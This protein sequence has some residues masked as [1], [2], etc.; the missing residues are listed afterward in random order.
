M[1]FN[2]FWWVYFITYPQNL[3]TSQSCCFYSFFHSWGHNIFSILLVLFISGNLH[4]LRNYT[5]FF[6]G[7]ALKHAWWALWLQL[8]INTWSTRLDSLVDDVVIWDPVVPEIL[9]QSLVH[10]RHAFQHLE[11]CSHPLQ[12]TYKLQLSVWNLFSICFK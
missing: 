5:L 1:Q 8:V 2:G 6:E 12:P 11:I 9:V 10:A 4:G 7:V 3:V